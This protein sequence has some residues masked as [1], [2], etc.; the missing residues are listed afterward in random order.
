MGGAKKFTL[1]QAEKQ[2]QMQTAKQEQQKTAKTKA[3][4]EK[5]TATTNIMNLNDKELVAE[6]TKMKAITPYQVAS[7]YNIKVSAAKDLLHRIERHGQLQ[8]IAS[9]GGLKVY[10]PVVT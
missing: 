5:K 9:S 7:R 6:L 3:A 8:I 4:L 10:R 2:Q 1:A